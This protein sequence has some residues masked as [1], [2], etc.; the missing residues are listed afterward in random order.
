MA[1]MVAQIRQ[2]VQQ[3]RS[4]LCTLQR[5]A[6]SWSTVASWAAA[7]DAI[8]LLSPMY[9]STL[10]A[11]LWEA[12]SVDPSLSVLKGLI[13]SVWTIVFLLS[14]IFTLSLQYTSS[15]LNPKP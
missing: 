8:Q 3:L 7:Q 9:K 10:H 14:T 2:Y 13:N 6:N 4:K 1:A 15:T 11:L 12:I 5:L